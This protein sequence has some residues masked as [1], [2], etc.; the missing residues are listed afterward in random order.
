[1][2][3]HQE[4]TYEELDSNIANAS[5]VDYL[6]PETTSK[7]LFAKADLLDKWGIY[8]NQ[9]NQN[10]FRRVILGPCS[11]R[12]L[13]KDFNGLVRNMIMM[14]SN[15]YF[16][17]NNHPEV[18]LAALKAIEKYGA[19]SGSV[20]LL[21]GT[22]DIHQELEAKLAAFKSC[23]SAM[24]FSSGF[25]SNYSIIT[26]ILRSNDYVINDMLNHASIVEGCKGAQ[27]KFGTKVEFFA[28]NNMKNL[29][30]KLEKAA[31][32]CT[33]DKLIIV[34]G[35]F[36]MDGDIAP[37]PEILTLAKEYNAK[38][39]IDEAHATGVLGKNGRGTPEHFGVEGEIDL[40]AGTLSK[41]LGVVGGF[42]AG[43]REVI[44]YLRFYG[45]GYVFSTSMTP[46]DAG[47]LIKALEIL[48]KDANLRAQLWR[49]INYMQKELT[50]LG[51][52]INGSE[53][54]II[55]VIIG[56]DTLTR[57]MTYELHKMDIF[58]NPVT[59]PAVS[60]K[61]SRLRLSL[62]ATHT[63]EDLDQTLSALELLGKKYGVI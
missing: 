50:N 22:L 16:E 60:R 35:V 10:L 42:V 63:M 34:D 52:N 18:K 24:V 5:L 20:P 62:M 47:A 30:Q 55:P 58:V 11:H 59:Y 13:V 41:G 40:V 45:P 51:F 38:V 32:D 53:T 3:K 48:E 14:G 49:N 19:G 17:L 6:E 1:M 43:K 4:Y 54:A 25:Q 29:R 61:R 9:T 46:G 33:G 44:Q 56:D 36:S 27:A 31:H 57:L 7:H 37:L 23:E 26:G 28:H 2:L 12:T 8:L 21:A 39:M 15:S